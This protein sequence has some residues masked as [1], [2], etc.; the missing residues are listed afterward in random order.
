DMTR[1]IAA[2]LG[3]T[4]VGPQIA[5]GRAAQQLFDRAAHRFGSGDF[6]LPAQKCEFSYLLFG[7]IDNRSHNDIVVRYQSA[8]KQSAALPSFLFSRLFLIEY[9]NPDAGNQAESARPAVAPYHSIPR[10]LAS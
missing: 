6:L 10:F 9:R 4:E 5:G 7:K 8:V 2:G 3:S 1:D